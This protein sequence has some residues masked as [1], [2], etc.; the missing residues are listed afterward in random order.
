MPPRINKS[1]NWIEYWN[2][3]DFWYSSKLWKVNV[4]MFRHRAEK[5]T[6]FGKNDAILNVGCG[7]GYLEALLAPRVKS[8]LAVDTSEHYIEMCRENCRMH[9]NVS[10]D[11]LNKNNYT[12]LTIFNQSF[13]LIL[14]VS[15]VQYYKSMDEVE[16]LIRSA[17]KIAKP[18]ARMLIADLPLKRGLPGFMWDAF[19]SL[20]MSI[21]EGYLPS[22]LYAAYAKYFR[23][24]KY[25]SFSNESNVL[26]FTI[27]DVKSLIER[28]G[29]NA[30][31]IRHSLS[32]YANRPSILIDL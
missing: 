31:I 5:I 2:E 6:G 9:P 21:K 26:S 22:L 3:D 18:G 20:M 23:K 15:V 32:I 11:I 8:I 27:R 13:S 4:E 1:E 19:G 17:K 7:P 25:G 30:A 24:A 16:S 14:C 29:L 28:M 12:D 10:A